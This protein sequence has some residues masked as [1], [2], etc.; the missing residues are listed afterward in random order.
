[1]SEVIA[2]PH[3]R[4]NGHLIS[5]IRLV[6]GNIVE[7]KDVDAIIGSISADL[8]IKGGL[9]RAIVAAAGEE[10]DKFILEHVFKPRPGDVVAVPSFKMGVN[11]ILFTVTPDWK[12]GEDYEDRD[13]VRCYRGAMQLSYRMNLRKI[14]FPALGTGSKKYPVKRAARLAI[15]GIM[16]RMTES[17]H[18]VRIVCNRQETYDAFHEWLLFYGWKDEH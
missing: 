18:E 6:Q 1:M 5:K 16:D 2:E 15:Q 4:S 3:P 14:A 9:N 10:M 8:D 17:F 12:G 11:H 7:Q 13:L